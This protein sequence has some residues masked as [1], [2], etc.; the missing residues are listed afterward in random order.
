MEDFTGEVRV[1]VLENT[2]DEEKGFDGD[3]PTSGSA[4]SFSDSAGACSGVGFVGGDDG[5][6]FLD[7]TLVDGVVIVVGGG[8]ED[9]DLERISC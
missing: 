5:E 9:R 6:D 2:E 8:S 3:G 4:N 1:P 7:V